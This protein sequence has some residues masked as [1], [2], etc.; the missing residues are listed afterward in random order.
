[1]EMA[2][3]AKV[4]NGEITFTNK[5]LTKATNEIFDNMTK[6]RDSF[7]K[8]VQALK[9]IRDKKLFEKD[10]VDPI[11]GKPS[12]ALYCEQI[13]GIS[14]SSAYSYI[15]LC[16]KLLAPESALDNKFFG[17]FSTSA[18]EVLSSAGESYTEVKAFCEE[19]N[20]TE[21]TPISSVRKIVKEKKKR[22]KA[23]K[24]GEEIVEENTKASADGAEETAESAEETIEEVTKTR[25]EYK[26][27]L[28]ELCSILASDLQGVCNLLDND[29]ANSVRYIVKK[30]AEV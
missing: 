2:I 12:F 1:M 22:D 23:E 21:S 13:L 29:S 30:F 8:A 20:I 9:R 27:Y 10:F 14:K 18:L 16:D 28:L 26:E 5:S 11:D 6:S 25:N 24:N 7:F 19:K 3:N 15:A 17:D 4:S